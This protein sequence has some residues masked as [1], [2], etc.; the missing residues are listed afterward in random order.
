MS[1]Q[2]S[3]FTNEQ[4][5]P[6]PPDEHEHDN[7]WHWCNDSWNTE[8]E[9]HNDALNLSI[10]VAGSPTSGI[11]RFIEHLGFFE[12]GGTRNPYR[13][14]P[15]ML[16]AVLQSSVCARVLELEQQRFD[17]QLEA[18]EQ[19]YQQ[20]TSLLQQQ[21]QHEQGLPQE[22]LQLQRYL[23][24]FHHDLQ[25]QRQQVQQQALQQ[26]QYLSEHLSNDTQC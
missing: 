4:Q 7:R 1:P 6:P 11:I 17:Q 5:S 18:L 10:K 21:L 22:Q 9:F 20:T 2:L 23:E 3:L 8:Y 24:Q 26:L 14:D 16:L 19:H 25:R 15:A 12:G 13:I